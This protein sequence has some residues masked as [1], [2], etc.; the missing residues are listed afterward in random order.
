MRGWLQLPAL[1]PAGRVRRRQADDSGEQ[2][3]G[4]S[5]L[6][7]Y[8]SRSAGGLATKGC[9]QTGAWAA[10][11]ENHS[12]WLG[13]KYLF[14]MTSKTTPNWPVEVLPRAV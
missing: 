3:R 6:S 7:V 14:I 13:L 9:A 2:L 8:A 4:F 1:S 12:D 5:G 10:A 11:S